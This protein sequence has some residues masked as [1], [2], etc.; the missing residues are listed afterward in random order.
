MYFFFSCF[1]SFLFFSQANCFLL[2]YH[3]LRELVP[4]ISTIKTG[5]KTIHNVWQIGDKME[6][7]FWRRAAKQ[8][9]TE[10]SERR[11][12]VIII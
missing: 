11:S 6:L 8:N 3:S 1:V 4:H 12:R 7:R 9:R 10:E 5:K 2:R